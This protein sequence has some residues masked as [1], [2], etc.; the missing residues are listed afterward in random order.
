MSENQT[1]VG[2][3]QNLYLPSF[4]FND[5]EKKNQR[6]TSSILIEH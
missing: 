6:V 1:K 2:Q 5:M 3:E 4:I